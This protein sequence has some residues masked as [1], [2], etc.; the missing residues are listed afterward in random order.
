MIKFF[1]HIR[2]NLIMENKTS[3]YFKYAIGEIVLVVIGILIALQINNWNENRKELKEEQKIIFSLN[4]EFKKNLTQLDSS[5]ISIGKSLKGIDSI[6]KVMNKTITIDSNPEKLDKLLS[7]VINTPKFF[8][9]SMVLKELESSGRLTKLKNPTLKSLLYLWNSK[10]DQ[11]T[12]TL[13]ISNNSFDDALDYI[14]KNASLRRIDFASSASLQLSQSII[15]QSN[16]HLL[17]DLQFENVVD[18]QYVLL[19]NRRTIYLDVK[20]IIKDIIKQTEPN[21]YD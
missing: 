16:E 9:S 3:K 11:M 15:S 2:Q 12:I 8:P 1:R 13:T 18:D 17:T 10:M 14:K 20:K 19:D 6:L 4:E 5:I 21:S 7:K